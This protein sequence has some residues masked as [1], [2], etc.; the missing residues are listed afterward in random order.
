[1]ATTLSPPTRCWSATGILGQ[2]S[3]S[4]SLSRPYSNRRPLR[5]PPPRVRCLL[6]DRLCVEGATNPQRLAAQGATR[7]YTAMRPARPDTGR[8]TG[9]SARKLASSGG[10]QS[11]LTTQLQH[12]ARRE[13]LRP[14]RAGAQ[15][16]RA[17]QCRHWR[18]APAAA[19]RKLLTAARAAR[20]SGTA[21]L[22]ARRVTGGHTSRC[23]SGPQVA[24]AMSLPTRTWRAPALSRATQGHCVRG[25]RLPSSPTADRAILLILAPKARATARSAFIML[26][27]LMIRSTSRARAFANALNAA[28]VAGAAQRCEATREHAPARQ[29]VRAR[30]KCANRRCPGG[31]RKRAQ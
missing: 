28:A 29:T 4:S 21:P 15:V 12:P 1:M 6:S 26:I 30:S 27:S 3:P 24:R 25:H 13:A 7:P 11:G 8:L 18:R 16:T 5:P 19:A 10:R 14:Q 17:A 31:L 20:R 22:A 2:R 9:G 23:A